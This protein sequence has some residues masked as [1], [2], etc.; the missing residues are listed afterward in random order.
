MTRLVPALM[1]ALACNAGPGR[2]EDSMP[3][4]NTPTSSSART[5]AIVTDAE[6]EQ[7][8]ALAI[9]SHGNRADL[10]GK[11][12]ALRWLADHAE[13]AYPLV[14]EHAKATPT[15]S[16]IEVVGRLG[17]PEAT[18]WLVEQL[19]AAGTA[20]GAAGISLGHTPDPHAREALLAAL[21]AQDP[22]VVI[23]AL[24]GLRVRGD[25]S[26][27]ASLAPLATH[28]DAEVRYVWVRTGAELGCIDAAALRKLAGSD[29]DPDVRHLATELA[30]AQRQQ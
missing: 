5:G 29:T 26:I 20:R 30:T 22:E 16:L 25:R 23:A 28:A 9:T 3:P 2:R 7:H 17:R 1:L 12:A 24:D 27:C 14:I 19:H 6:I 21:A 15:P 13:R 4:S 18:P 8:L 10:V 11:E